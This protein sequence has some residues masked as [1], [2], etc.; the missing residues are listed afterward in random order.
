MMQESFARK[1]VL[2][3][4][5]GALGV[6]AQQPDVP[7]YTGEL[8]IQNIFDN[9][10][11]MTAASNSDGAAVTL[12][13]CTGAASQKWVF[14]D[15]SVKVHGNKCLDVSSGADA[16]GTKMQIFTCSSGNANQQWSYDVWSKR[17]SWKGHNKCLDLSAGSTA[18]GNRLQ[19]WDCV[20]N[21]NQFWNTGYL[22]NSLPQTSQA[23]QFGTNNCGTSSD[24]NSKCQTAWINSADDFCVWAPP[25]LEAIGSS[26]RYEVAWCTKSG[27][28]T[29]VIPDG[30]LKGVHF[31]ETPD[32]VQITGQ[33][34]FTK[35]NI[36]AGD[37]G[38]EL[39]NRGA[40][41]RGN[42]IGGLVYGNSFGQGQQFH[43]WTNFMSDHE[44]C[45]RACRGPKAMELCNHVF[46]EMGC[47]WNMP[48]NYDP[49]FE[50]CEGVDAEPMGVY[51]V[52]GQRS[53]YTQGQS[54]TPPPHPAPSSSNC[55]ALPT[56]SSS[57]VQARRALDRKFVPK[58]PEHTP[59]PSY[60]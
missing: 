44:F 47:Y 51:T 40:D 3:A 35:I 2:A 5:I 53:T 39:D 31:V 18:D 21:P 10:K 24:Q 6:L 56:V 7:T 15:G 12:Q 50:N 46:D 1:V 42:P 8:V 20:W 52:D 49:G 29:R 43:E 16:N 26:E 41:G 25:A 9:G 32:Y 4:M 36:P 54:P 13:G 48:A 37:S 17:L 23:E 33:G 60:F 55:Q 34:D 58:F 19:I 30:T 45:F 14:Q 22:S 28:G 27:R 38:G 11:C 57:P 59:A